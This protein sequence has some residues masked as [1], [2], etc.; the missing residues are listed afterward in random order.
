MK[1]IKNKML[2]KKNISLVILLI[3]SLFLL[4]I[5][6][7]LATPK[8][9]RQQATG[10]A[11]LYFTPAT[12]SSGPIQKNIND[13]ITLDLMLDP[14]SSRISFLRF[15]IIYD[16]TKLSVSG[17]SAVQINSTTFP[18]ILEGP[19]L[20]PGKVAASLS[21]G[22]DP[23]KAFSSTSNVA[24]ITFTA[25]ATTNG[26]IQITMGDLTQA[27]SIG[28]NDSATD[29]VL[30]STEPA[31]IQIGTSLPTSTEP[32]VVNT[33]TT[34][35]GATP[36]NT[37][38]TIPL[39]YSPARTTLDMKLLFHGLG[40]AGDSKNET[41]DLSNK[42]PLHQ[43]RTLNVQIV[44]ED[45]QIVATKL[46]PAFY[47]SDTGHFDSHVVINDPIP[48]GDYIV[49]VKTDPYL[50]KLMPGFL[51]V[52][53]GAKNVMKPTELVAG[54]IN[55]D[56][57]INVLDYNVLYDCGYGELDPLP[58]IN[59]KSEFNNK[60]CSG[61]DERKHADL[62]DNGTIASPD[63]NLFIRELSVGFGQ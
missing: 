43:E 6:R 50:R 2:H 41:G 15:D 45:N 14:S 11:R 61:H 17:P 33:P 38:P 56:N 29:N 8:E 36:T 54:D 58:M 53:S 16:A 49:K 35:V 39:T 13:T 62:D 44:N 24:R 10:A 19:V 1:T 34:I 18:V 21:V 27:L 22:S 40:S 5:A 4:I 47:N 55:G 52:K 59:N 63:Y 26:P 25:L 32:P 9:T 46:A 23:T 28:A 42:N 20:T 51:T 7:L 31:F 12:S 37:I 60:R 30:G 48:D 3:L 57:V